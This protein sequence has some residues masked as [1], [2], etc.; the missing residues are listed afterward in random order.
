MKQIKPCP[1]CGNKSGWFEKHV[2]SGQQYFY[3]DG[4]PSHFCD[5]YTR[6]GKRKYC[7]DC[8]RD[9][10]SIIKGRHET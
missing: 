6:G 4:Q 5:E 3:A 2:T 1:W 10:T 8:N 7:A 9:I